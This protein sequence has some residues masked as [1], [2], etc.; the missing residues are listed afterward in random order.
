MVVENR[1]RVVDFSEES[2]ADRLA[3]KS[4]EAPYVPIGIY[5]CSKSNTRS[6]IFNFTNLQVWLDAWVQ[7][8][9]AYTNIKTEE[10][11]RHQFT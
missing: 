8:S 7:F 9:M 3:R 1:P 2:Q 10:K 6:T 4:K 11:C 5:S